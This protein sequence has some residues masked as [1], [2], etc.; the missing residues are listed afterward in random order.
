MKIVTKIPTKEANRI[1]PIFYFHMTK[2]HKHNHF[3]RGFLELLLKE[4]G[5]LNAK[6]NRVHARV[7]PIKSEMFHKLVHIYEHIVERIP[8]LNWFCTY[9]IVE[10]DNTA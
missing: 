7:Y 9:N 1:N 8:I 3:T 5:I 10:V 6:L 4:N 2:I